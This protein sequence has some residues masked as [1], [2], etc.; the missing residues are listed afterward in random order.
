MTGNHLN[1]QVVT[2]GILN[3]TV[4]VMSGITIIQTLRNKMGIFSTRSNSCIPAERLL[5][6]Y[7]GIDAIHVTQY[8]VTAKRQRNVKHVTIALLVGQ[9]SFKNWYVRRR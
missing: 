4:N 5:M 3:V 8:G 1:A 9:N 7:T 6:T 2:I